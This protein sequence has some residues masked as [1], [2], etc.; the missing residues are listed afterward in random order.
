V[1]RWAT[2]A[3]GRNPENSVVSVTDSA[4]DQERKIAAAEA[5]LFLAREP[6]SSRKLSQYANLADGTEARTLV[7]RLNERLDQTGR[8][9]RAQEVAGGFQLTTRR[10]FAKW[11]RRLDYLPSAERM[12]APSLETLAVVAYRQ[13][14]LRA[15]IEAVRG[16]GCGEILNQ[17]MSRDL[18]RVGGRSNE[19]GRP[20]LYNTTKRFLQLFGLKSLEDLPRVEAFRLAAVLPPAEPSTTA[21]VSNPGRV[22]EVE[23]ES[24]VSVSV[25]REQHPNIMDPTETELDADRL[26]ERQVRLEDEDYE[27]DI[28]EDEDDDFEDEDEDEDEGLEDEEEDD[29]EDEELEDD[30]EYEDEDDEELEDDEEYEDEED[31]EGEEGEEGEEDEEGEELEDDEEYEDEED[32]DE[33]DEELE[34]DEEY[35]DE[36]DEE[37][38]DDEEYED[39]EE[40]EEDDE[41]DAE[42]DEEELEEDEW[43]EVDEEEEDE[44]D[45]EDWDEEDW[46]DEEEDWEEE[47]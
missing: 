33:E 39:E 24:D 26:D 8:A 12:S 44:E 9:F 21:A 43:E 41:E 32:E 18:I 17:L 40:D 34:D 7:R 3:D 6:L 42:G 25:E 10:K 11:L 16:V 46:E 47:A 29:V 5:V 23:E 45:D 30:E 37:L 22:S 31:E 15:D 14:V 36:E 20:Y 27:E 1:R 2:D 4:E 19:L 13:P 35:E 28:D 38:E